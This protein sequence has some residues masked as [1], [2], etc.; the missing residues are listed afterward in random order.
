MSTDIFV[1]TYKK[2]LPFFR[3]LVR[4][5]RRFGT[6]FSGFV[7][8]VP[9][10][11]VADFREAISGIAEA[12]VFG[13][14]EHAKGHLKHQSIKMH[15]DEF[16]GADF[17]AHLDSDCLFTETVSPDDFFKDGKPI[18]W[19]EKYADFKLE[20]PVR[21]GWKDCV[22]NSTGI[23][24]QWE[25]MC[26]HPSVY[27]RSLYLVARRLITNH[28]GMAFDDHVLAGRNEFPHQFAEFPTLGAIALWVMPEA[29]HWHDANLASLTPSGWYRQYPG[30][31]VKMYWS[32]KGVEGDIQRDVEE[33]L[34]VP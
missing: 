6:G 17:I 7:V 28:T 27:P 14:Q 22:K 26:R 3:N 21:Y 15:A 5:Y 9:F 11:D 34:S 12:R 10:E 20:S 18:V 2:D 23:D 25:T 13:Y 4:S 24:A 32:H 19:R 31:K 29:I 33:I 1:V 8:A 16:C 30:E